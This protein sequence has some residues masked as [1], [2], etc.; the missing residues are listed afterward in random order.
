[1]DAPDFK[2]LIERQFG[3]NPTETEGRYALSSLENEAL[4]EGKKVEVYRLTHWDR[5]SGILYI[6]MG[7]GETLKLDGKTIK[8]ASNGDD[9]VYFAREK[10]QQPFK[11]DLEKAISPWAYLTD[12]LNFEIGELV[13]LRPE[14]QREVAKFWVLSLFFT[15]EL[16]TKP[17]L[18]LTGDAGSGKSLFLRRLLHFLYGNGDLDTIRGQD[19]FWASLSANH[20]LALDDLESDKTPKWV[21]PEL[22]RAATG[23]TI[24]LR[25]LYTTNTQVSFTPRCFVAF[26]SINPPIDDSALAERLI[27]LRLK[28][29]PS[30]TPESKLLRMVKGLRDRM[31][32]GLILELNALIPKLL[33][34]PPDSTFRM[35]DWASLIERIEGRDKVEPLLQG[36]TTFQDEAL[37]EDSPLPAIIEEWQSGK[38]VWLTPAQLYGEWSTLSQ[39][40]GLYFPFKNARSLAMHLTNVRHNLARVFGLDWEKSIKRGSKVVYRFSK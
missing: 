29:R 40:G 31:W 28:K 24:S 15:E 25:K 33:E 2:A 3:L 27:I 14:Q 21:I 19:D 8:R 22:K 12:D 36:L 1:M 16:P 4:T 11:P 34:P 39:E 30:K 32:D 7:D 10:W 13:A 38:D 20:L 9:G 18:C 26:T 5:A 35:A 37:L 23:Q 6:D 17:I